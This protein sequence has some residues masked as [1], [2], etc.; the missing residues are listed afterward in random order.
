MDNTRIKE[1]QAVYEKNT[2]RGQKTKTII[3][4]IVFLVFAVIGGL[5]LYGVNYF[6]SGLGGKLWVTLFAVVAVAL[7]VFSHGLFKKLPFISAKNF[8]LGCLLYALVLVGIVWLVFFIISVAT[9]VYAGKDALF[10]YTKVKDWMVIP[11]CYSL[12]SLGLI[13][14][15]LLCT[16]KCKKCYRSGFGLGARNNYVI[17]KITK[18]HVDSVRRERPSEVI[19]DTE[20]YYETFYRNYE[21]RFYRHYCAVCGTIVHDKMRKVK[22]SKKYSSTVELFSEKEILAN[23][24]RIEDSKEYFAKKEQKAM[25][26]LYALFEKEEQKSQVKEENTTENKQ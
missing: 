23:K 21:Y 5:I 19:G 11:L 10:M 13:I 7:F 2:K 20:A 22:C 16:K 17:E 14:V 12:M 4:D 3:Y 25:K 6:V 15:S 1:L 24:K 18:E 26:K 8:I 9:K